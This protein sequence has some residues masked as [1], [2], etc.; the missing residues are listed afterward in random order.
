M[1]IPFALNVVPPVLSYVSQS[2]A[3]AAQLH[4]PCS[5]FADS[6]FLHVAPVRQSATV[7]LAVPPH[8]PSGLNV[9]P[10]LLSHWLS[11][12]QFPFAA[13]QS[14]YMYVPSVHVSVPLS[15]SYVVLPAFVYVHMLDAM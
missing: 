7:V 13:V 14:E 1:H 4:V 15:H 5:T 10:P 2:V 6:L 9:V 12:M 8:I 11:D 3:V